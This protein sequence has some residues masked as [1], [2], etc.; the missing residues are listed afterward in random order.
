MNDEID[1]LEK[2]PFNI[3]IWK[4][5][6]ECGNC[7]LHNE[8]HCEMHRSD[9]L[10][11]AGSAMLFFIPSIGGMLYGGMWLW[12]IGYFIYW[13]IFFELWENR[14]LCSH[15]PFYAE[16][17]G[18]G[19]TLH[20]YANYGLYKTWPYNPSPMSRSHQ[21]QFLVALVIFAGYPIP[22]LILS[23]QLLFLGFTI[24]GI[25]VWLSVLKFKI[26]PRCLNFSCPLNSVP[27]EIVDAFLRRNP[28]MMKSWIESGYELS[29]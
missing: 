28:V 6:E 10:M 11:F 20:C 1:Q 18:Q 2:N 4:P 8:I 25:G 16:N 7:S 13:A 5:K 15:C 24:M 21:I 27:K 23:N 22:F 3:C 17:G 29:A 12:V 14:V 19:H 26:C 9:T